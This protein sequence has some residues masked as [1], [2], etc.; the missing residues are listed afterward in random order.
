MKTKFARGSER[1]FALQKQ[2]LLDQ[3]ESK[4]RQYVIK[5]ILYVKYK[6][7]VIN[8]RMLKVINFRMLLQ[9]T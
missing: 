2:K 3:N 9:L 4:V 8:F 1:Y 5:T 6:L 7:K